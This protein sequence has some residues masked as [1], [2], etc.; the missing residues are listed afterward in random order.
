MATCLMLLHHQPDRIERIFSTWCM[1]RRHARMPG[2]KG[3][4]IGE[5][6]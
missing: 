2:C 6:S 1:A 3:A 4:L 5:G